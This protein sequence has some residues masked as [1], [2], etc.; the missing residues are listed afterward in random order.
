M[1]IRFEMS[2]NNIIFWEKSLLVVNELRLLLVFYLN[3]NF[4]TFDTLVGGK[5]LL[6]LIIL[7]KNSN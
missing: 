4:I 3:K 2:E 6:S 7:T 5:D 1:L